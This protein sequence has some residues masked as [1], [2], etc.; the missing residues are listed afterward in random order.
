M[1]QALKL[2]EDTVMICAQKTDLP[3][4][5]VQA[6]LELSTSREYESYVVFD[7][8]G[9]A[10]DYV[11]HSIMRSIFFDQRFRFVYG[12]DPKKFMPVVTI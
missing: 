4:E 3:I 12:E 8:Y 7:F 1:P 9:S 2:T 11:P 6:W 10:G 5:D